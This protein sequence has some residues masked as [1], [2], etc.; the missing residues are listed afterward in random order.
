MREKYFIILTVS[1]V[2]ALIMILPGMALVTAIVTLGAAFILYPIILTSTVLLA[3]LFPFFVLMK[4]R[5]GR[6]VGGTLSAT[7][8]ALIFALPQFNA[9]MQAKA[10]MAK[11]AV[12][13]A[14]NTDV[15]F[16]RGWSWHRLTC[17]Q[18]GF[19]SIET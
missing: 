18:A 16:V 6:W 3:C 19:I 2:L 13:P 14:K 5:W 17:R 11:H 10:L 12:T 15:S 8:V 9:V 1:I 7:L 4:W